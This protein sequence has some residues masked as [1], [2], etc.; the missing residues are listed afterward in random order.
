MSRRFTFALT[1]PVGRP[2]TTATTAPLATRPD[3]CAAAAAFDFGALE[4]AFRR[5]EAGDGIHL[6]LA[7]AAAAAALMMH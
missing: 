4:E 6:A 3:E 1:F 2:T 7:A 5:A